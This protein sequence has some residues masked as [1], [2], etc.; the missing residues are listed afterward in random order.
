MTT[1]NQV[2]VNKYEAAVKQLTERQQ[3]VADMLRAGK[4]PDEIARL[5]RMQQGAVLSIVR[6]VMDVFVQYMVDPIASWKPEVQ[7]QYDA[8]LNRA[9][10]NP[11]PGFQE[12]PDP[13]DVPK[14]Q[15]NVSSVEAVP[16]RGSI[17]EAVP[18]PNAEF[19][20]A[21]D[22]AM[23]KLVVGLADGALDVKAVREQIDL[24]KEIAELRQVLPLPP[25]PMESG[26]AV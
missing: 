7:R 14:A 19:A 21:I 4:T 5:L 6:R 20:Q 15:P 8:A 2:H 12:Q 23:T 24:M 1:P 3:E 9:D 25:R 17:V 26:W 18:P 10:P 22:R 13:H 16:P 11:P